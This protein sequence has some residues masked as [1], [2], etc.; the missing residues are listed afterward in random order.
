MVAEQSKWNMK[1]FRIHFA[2]QEIGFLQKRIRS[3]RLPLIDSDG[4]WSLGTNGAYLRSLLHHWCEEYDW[5]REE[6]YLNRFPQFTCELDGLTI[7]F[8]HIRSAHENAPALL[9][10]HGWPDSFLRYAKLF[11]LLTGYHLVV[12]SLPGFAFST[13]PKKGYMNNAETAEVWHKLMTEVLGYREYA[14]SGGD[15]GRGDRKS[16]V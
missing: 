16:V 6:E 9:L 11:P 1:S 7:H 10:T 13:L 4:D 14:A 12:P 15:M 3:S 5:H 2:E 8:F